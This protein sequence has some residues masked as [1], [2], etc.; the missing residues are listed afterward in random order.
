MLVEY[1][2]VTS[3][4]KDPS[5]GAQLVYATGTLTG[6]KYVKT[7]LL[8]LRG[9]AGLVKVGDHVVMLTIGQLQY[10][11]LGIVEQNDLELE[12]G[13]ALLYGEEVKETGQNK[14]FTTRTRV[15]INKDY[16]VQLDTLDANKVTKASI[17]LD[18]TGNITIMATGTVTVNA[19]SVSLP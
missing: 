17:K 6:K 11:A 8:S 4:T 14:V 10:I 9:V 5:R 12:E 3:V 19:P 13:E 1:A 15:K 18:Q 7:E 2:L 16:S